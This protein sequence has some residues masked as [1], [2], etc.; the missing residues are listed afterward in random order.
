MD[1]SQHKGIITIS[2]G[3]A[4]RQRRE[5]SKLTRSRLASLPLKLTV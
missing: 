5:R 1:S 2:Y 4:Q 3:T